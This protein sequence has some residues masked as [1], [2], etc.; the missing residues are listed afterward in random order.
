MR[1]PK[2]DRKCSKGK[3]VISSQR[4][5]S[6]EIHQEKEFNTV[7]SSCSSESMQRGDN[8]NSNFAASTSPTASAFASIFSDI[9]RFSRT[10]KLSSP[11][12]HTS[13]DSEQHIP[14]YHERKRQLNLSRAREKIYD[15]NLVSAQMPHYE[16]LLDA[17]LQDYFNSPNTRNHL[18]RLG[19]IDEEGNIVSAKLFK[20]SQIQLDKKEYEDV[21]RTRQIEREIDRDI[22]L[23]IHKHSMTQHL[24]T[25]RIGRTDENPSPFPNFF[26][27]F[28]ISMHTTALLYLE[29]S[30]SK[31]KAE[32]IFLKRLQSQ[33]LTK[34]GALGV[35]SA[36][37]EARLKIVERNHK[38]E[39]EKKAIQF[40]KGLTTPAQKKLDSSRTSHEAVKN[41]QIEHDHQ[42]PDIFTL[43]KH[44]YE[45]G[46]T[47]MAETY[48]RQLLSIVKKKSSL[49]SSLKQQDNHSRLANK[50]VSISFDTIVDK[51]SNDE[52]NEDA[53]KKH[54][55]T[56]SDPK[57]NDSSQ[58]RQFVRP[59]SARPSRNS[60][61]PSSTAFSD[62]ESEGDTDFD[63]HSINNLD[64]ELSRNASQQDDSTDL[65]SFK[66]VDSTPEIKSISHMTPRESVKILIHEDPA[67][68]SVFKTIDSS[69][70]TNN[71][72]VSSDSEHYEPVVH[73]D[74]GSVKEDHERIIIESCDSHIS[75]HSIETRQQN[76]SNLSGLKHDVYSHDQDHEIIEHPVESNLDCLEDSN[77]NNAAI[78]QQFQQ[79]ASKSA[80]S[81]EAVAIDR[82]RI[83][84]ESSEYDILHY[85]KLHHDVHA[86]Q[87]RNVSEWVLVEQ[88]HLEDYTHDDCFQEN[89]DD[90]ANL[91]TN[92]AVQPQEKSTNV[93][94]SE[95]NIYEHQNDNHTQSKIMHSVSDTAN[96]L[97]TELDFDEYSQNKP[98]PE[99]SKSDENN[100]HSKSTY[101]DDEFDY[102]KE[103]VDEQQA[104]LLTKA[105]DFHI[106]KTEIEADHCTGEA[107]KRQD[108]ST[109]NGD[110]HSDKK[111]ECA[112]N[113]KI[114]IDQ[115][116]NRSNN[117]VSKHQQ[118]QAK[119]GISK[120]G[121]ISRSSSTSHPLNKDAK[122]KI[123]YRSAALYTPKIKEVSNLKNPLSNSARNQNTHGSMSLDK[124][125]NTALPES[126]P[127]SRVSSAHNELHHSTKKISTHGSMS[128]DKAKNTA[129]PESAPISRVSS[130]HNE[131][132]H[133]TKKISTHGSMS[134]DKAKS[135]ALPE[136]AP[137][138]RVSSAHNELH[139]STKKV[140]THGSM[141]LDKAKSTALPES[142]P[143]SR[144]SSAHNELHHSTKKISTHGSMSL[145]KAKNTALPESAPISR[146][147][148]AHNELHHSTKKIST[149]GSMSL[150]KA[151]STALPESAPISRVSSAHNEL[152]HSTKK[153]STHGSMSLDKAKSTALPESAP[154]S[155]V[156]SAHN[157]LHHSTKKVSTHGSMSLDK[158]KNTALPESAPISRVS[159]AH[160]ELHYSTKKISTHGSMSLDKAKSTALPE[161][162]PISRVSSAH[163]ELH[164]S[165]KKVSTHGSMSLDK[166]KNTAL[167]ESAPISRASSARYILTSAEKIYSRTTSKSNLKQNGTT[168]KSQI[169]AS[170]HALHK[171]V[172]SCS[173]K[174]FVHAENIV[175]PQHHS[176]TNDYHAQSTIESDIGQVGHI[177]DAIAHHSEITHGHKDE[178]T[179]H[180]SLSKPFDF[181]QTSHSHNYQDVA[182][183]PKVSALY[184]EKLVPEVVH[185]SSIKRNVHQ[186]K[187]T[188]IP[189]INQDCKSEQTRDHHKINSNQHLA[190]HQSFQSISETCV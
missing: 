12:G 153:I 49:T 21:F 30:H 171:S 56:L 32:H 177:H 50:S 8:T 126:A 82:S 26:Q 90:K 124:A 4:N 47:L 11:R 109:V 144:V 129:L 179:H 72:D 184:Q 2:G 160:N 134:L 106:G 123:V 166:A 182:E 155:R 168:T 167:P 95:T 18:I 175:T 62:C 170:E 9:S 29:S 148:S 36:E 130:A 53:L 101:S 162:A 79:D 41:H 48:L 6:T 97:A 44:E 107:W 39:S 146:V 27:H 17:N 58:H 100:Q 131:L 128:L 139:H 92:K 173:T 22:E 122:N 185:I 121:L 65:G 75:E 31:L 108:H 59:K 38:K 14:V 142:A 16:P 104:Q 87:S 67:V 172:S 37:V 13:S 103:Y 35:T 157:E 74:S 63:L 3:N 112:S 102:K 54:E 119:Q 115:I 161:S 165:T 186:D 86:S 158:A 1:G 70:N 78:D 169:R 178:H 94:H 52:I 19:L 7:K 120:S 141:S 150:D 110:Q 42:L 73:L 80:N 149:H 81:H 135:T 43:A 98:N 66:N 5:T 45:I 143:I 188:L 51:S 23:A 33:S 114:S 91:K 46:N 57:C 10:D 117:N 15:V 61:F 183:S 105:S 71:K 24:R 164:H 154:I 125:K 137:I 156:S 136:S 99:D 77:I 111:L 60:T 127:I 151:K 40:R 68:G 140:S 93:L 159:S 76:I 147:S 145:D 174:D 89:F 133:S 25:N 96:G 34:L 20:Y 88:D 83:H 181:Q 163:N 190:E 69:D 187:E 113:H 84:S 85:P 176:N 152:H 28:P 64:T 118:F 189:D 138:S 116:S 132:H 180:D 55:S